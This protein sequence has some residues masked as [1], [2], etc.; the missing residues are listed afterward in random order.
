M[1]LTRNREIRYKDSVEFI[2]HVT[3]K[4][5][6]SWRRLPE[7]FSTMIIFTDNTCTYLNEG[8]LMDT[9]IV[10]EPLPKSICL[11]CGEEM[12]ISNW[13]WKAQC[14]ITTKRFWEKV[15]RL[16]WHRYSRNKIK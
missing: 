8:A 16:Y 2:E 6:K 15:R 7:R 5:V 9:N 11:S 3:G 12:H 14:Q 4:T 10:F 13:N 1:A